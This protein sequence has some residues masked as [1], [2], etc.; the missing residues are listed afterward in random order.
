MNKV[1]IPEGISGEWK[2]EKFTVA[3]DDALR[4]FRCGVPP[5]VYTRLMCNGS[6]LMSDTPS[7]MRDHSY[8]LH[9]ATGSVLINGLGIGMVLQAV[10]QKP[11]VNCVTVNELSQDVINLVSPT[12]INRFPSKVRI[13][14]AD[15]YKWK[16]DNGNKYDAIWHDIWGDVSTDQL[17]DMTRLSRRYARWLAP[18][19]YQ[20]CWKKEFLQHQKRR[21]R[22][23]FW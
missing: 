2:V 19:G 4:W 16:P 5:G 10:A 14:H 15:A 13:N 23:R 21:E 7:E 12:Y 17:Q 8:F 3:R 18:G 11:E 9:R 6:L 20:G 22:N 1:D